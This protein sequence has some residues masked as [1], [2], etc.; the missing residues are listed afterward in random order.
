MIRGIKTTLEFLK[1]DI[2]H[3]LKDRAI[4]DMFLAGDD[5]FDTRGI[6]PLVHLENFISLK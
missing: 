5:P 3:T 4:K 6:Q 1:H 2:T